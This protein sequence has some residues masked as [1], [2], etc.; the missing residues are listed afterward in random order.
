MGVGFLSMYFIITDR[1]ENI[2]QETIEAKSKEQVD[3]IN[4]GFESTNLIN[5]DWGRWDDTY[6]FAKD[7]N[8]EFIDNNFDLPEYGVLKINAIQVINTKAEIV[9]YGSRDYINNQAYTK[10]E[11]IKPILAKIVKNLDFDNIDRSIFGYFG[12]DNIYYFAAHQITKSVV[13]DN[14]DIAGVIIFVKEI[15]YSDP[16]NLGLTI[17]SNSTI[18]L[19]NYKKEKGL[20]DF[21]N[22]NNKNLSKL[23]VNKEI[24]DY[25][26]NPILI[27]RL[28][29]DRVYTTE[30][31]MIFMALVV[32]LLLVFASFSI[33]I[34]FS[35]D[36]NVFSKLKIF[37]NF[38]NKLSDPMTSQERLKG[39]L[40]SEFSQ[41][42]GTINGLL[43][44]IQEQ[45]KE[46]DKVNNEFKAQ[47]EQLQTRQKELNER[48]AELNSLNQAMIG[49]EMRMIELKTQM[50]VL[51]KKV[52][53]IDINN[54]NPNP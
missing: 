32:I 38:L 28:Q 8:Q 29:V 2:E 45:R 37:S 5:K 16:K 11:E 9:Y 15:D 7:G 36:R 6:N 26:G 18:D 13:T 35:I 10:D 50:D 20:I 33:L 48:N 51:N 19:L 21:N 1:F 41:L 14:S 23:V 27:L 52:D 47:N 46:V 24:T 3:I 4:S 31:L 12:A 17:P 22:S 30:S 42:Q 54:P 43:D 34:Y 40:G 25:F 49:R 39:N 44:N 53:I